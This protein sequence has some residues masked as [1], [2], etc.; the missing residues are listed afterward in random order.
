VA[1]RRA[2]AGRTASRSS[3]RRDWPGCRRRHGR[4]RWRPALAPVVT[5]GPSRTRPRSPGAT[6]AAG[7]PGPQRRAG[8]YG[9]NRRHGTRGLGAT[10]RAEGR[11]GRHRAEGRP[12]R[13]QPAGTARPV[14]RAHARAQR[15][16]DDS[17]RRDQRGDGEPPRGSVAT[18]GGYVITPGSGRPCRCLTAPRAAMAGPCRW[19]IPRQARRPRFAPSR[20]ALP[21]LPRQGERRAAGETMQKAARGRRSARHG[22]RAHRGSGS[23]PSRGPAPVMRTL[24]EASARPVDRRVR[25]HG[26]R[27]ARDAR[28]RA[29]DHARKTRRKRPRRAGDVRPS[30]ATDRAVAGRARILRTAG[31]VFKFGQQKRL[32]EGDDAAV[33]R[34]RQPD[35]KR[36]VRVG[37]SGRPARSWAP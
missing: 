11:H 22:P 24:R 8:R 29:D 6:A 34:W 18:G 19:T 5:A 14:R 27:T 17:E 10:A 37:A 32:I 15:R 9:R 13:D 36:R 12:G 1:H 35:A 7:R 20:S 33:V 4:A 3:A 30:E 21:D 25:A 16:A 2:S 31:D 23:P 26:E 28:R